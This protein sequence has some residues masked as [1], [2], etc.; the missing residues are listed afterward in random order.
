MLSAVAMTIRAAFGILLGLFLGA[1]GLYIG[2]F[3]T[4]PGP[5]LPTGLLVTFCGL[6]AGI[7]GFLSY[8][9]PEVPSTVNILNLS[10]ALTVG[11]VGAWVGWS[12]GDLIYPE[13]VY[14]PAAPIRTPPFVV[15]VVG[16]SVGANIL[17]W[18]F[19]TY[20]LFRHREI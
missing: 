16:A 1:I 6:G 10:I 13:G 20:R 5:T 15:S 19:Y 18:C 9:K 12:L 7:G 3:I 8:F 14:N 4:P 11:I 2:W 17:S